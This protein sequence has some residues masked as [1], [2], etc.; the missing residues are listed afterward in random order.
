[1]RGRRPNFVVPEAAQRLSGIQSKQSRPRSGR[2]T[3]LLFAAILVQGSPAPVSAAELGRLFLTPAE[4]AQL[5]E[6]RAPQSEPD[7]ATIAE[8][9]PTDA[10]SE[11]PA[12]PITVNGIVRRSDGT[13][14]V[15]INGISSFDGDT[16]ALPEYV[17]RASLSSGRVTL[18]DPNGLR[19][20]VLKPGQTYDPALGAVSEFHTPDAEAD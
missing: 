18:K 8:G 4:R 15:W 5:E 14:T 10:G 17:D 6:L 9:E 2:V 11:Q 3:L 19:T 7:D 20:I 1:M 16:E 13:R 12:L